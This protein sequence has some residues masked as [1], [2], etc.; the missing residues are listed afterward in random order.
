[1]ARKQTPPKNFED[2][3]GELEKILSEIEVGEVPLE[4]SLVKYER[5]QFLIKYCRGVL[6]E[7]EKQIEQLSKAEDGT[8]QSEPMTESEE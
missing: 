4:D 1:M 5:G 2:A 3:L 8:L 6:G 7:A